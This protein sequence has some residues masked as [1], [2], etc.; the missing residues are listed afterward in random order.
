MRTIKIKFGK[1]FLLIILLGTFCIN[2]MAQTKSGNEIELLLSRLDFKTEGYEVVKRLAANPDS[3]ASALLKYYRQRTS[4]KHPV[5]R[6]LKKVSPVAVAG[7]K[8]LDIANNALKH[9][10]VGQTAYPP[11]FCGEDIDW[12]TRPVPDN[13]WVWQL[14]RMYFWDAM[15]RAY[16]HTGDEKY[17]AE[18]CGQLM[19]W[20]QRIPTMNSIKY[21]WRSI[22]A[23]I[24]G[25]SWTSIVSVLYRFPNVYSRCAGGIF[26]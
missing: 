10:F 21:A 16:W 5:D 24:R 19:D 7:E 14:N 13:E 15:A 4:V 25:H 3:T 20:I 23:G 26:K 8:N 12:N 11:Y 6:N 9:I 2:G 22:E 17:A 1:S 18:W